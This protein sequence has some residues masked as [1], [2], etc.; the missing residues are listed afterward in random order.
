VVYAK[1]RFPSLDNAC[2]GIPE[3]RC[4][5]TESDFIAVPQLSVSD[6]GAIVFRASFAPVHITLSLL[7]GEQRGRMRRE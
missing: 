5:G 4:D 6:R 2:S 7:C 1:L 3:N